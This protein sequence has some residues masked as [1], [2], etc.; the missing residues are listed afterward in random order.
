MQEMTQM[1][2]RM[3]AKENNAEENEAPEAASEHKPGEQS[4]DVRSEP[5]AKPTPEEEIAK[6]KDQLLR[7]MA[8]ME[9]LRR[10]TERDKEDI[11]KYAIASFARDLV[12]VADNLKRAEDAIP[13]DARAGDGPL[14][15]LWEGVDLTRREL[16]GVFERHGIKRLDPKGEKFDHNFHQAVAQ[17]ETKDAEPGTVMDVFQAGYV[18]FNRLLKPAM[19]TVAKAPDTNDKPAGTTA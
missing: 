3:S 1:K 5:E 8:E 13:E 2:D 14:K 9:N 4:S 17:V 16:L 11:G 7:T 19:V 12:A 10:R 6:L 15:T 18:I